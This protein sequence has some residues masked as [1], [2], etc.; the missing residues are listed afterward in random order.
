MNFDK[1]SDEAVELV[2]QDCVFD[3]EKA[4]EGDRFLTV[5]LEKVS[6]D[7][8]KPGSISHYAGR[9]RCLLCDL[10]SQFHDHKVGG[11]PKDFEKNSKGKY[12][13]K[14]YLMPIKLLHL[15]VA[16]GF[17]MKPN[18]KVPCYCLGKRLL[19]D[20]WVGKGKLFVIKERIGRYFVTR[21]YLEEDFSASA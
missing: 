18:N 6:P 11:Y 20:T 17:L 19:V 16:A 14:S 13:S 21:E 3:P 5:R 8:F 4:K 9:I 1:L 10:P 15:A 7:H 2:F 12:W